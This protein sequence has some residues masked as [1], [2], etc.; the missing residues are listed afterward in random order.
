[1]D[2]NKELSAKAATAVSEAPGETPISSN[3]ASMLLQLKGVPN[4]EEEGGDLKKSTCVLNFEA[5]EEAKSISN[6][7]IFDSSD[8]CERIFDLFLC[9]NQAKKNANANAANV[10]KCPPVAES[11]DICNCKKSRCL[12][13]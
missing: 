8:R 6:K 12:K 3:L 1:M 9:I 7:V 4:S 2:P 13:L 11:Q 5:N 10:V